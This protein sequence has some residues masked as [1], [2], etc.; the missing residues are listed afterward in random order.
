MNA[1]ERYTTAYCVKNNC[2]LSEMYR[3]IGISPN[4]HMKYVRGAQPLVSKGYKISQFLGV[5]I[6]RLWEVE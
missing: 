4:N 1:Y 6:A 3:R 2:S 5:N